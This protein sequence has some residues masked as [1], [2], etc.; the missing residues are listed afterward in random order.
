[1]QNLKDSKGSFGMTWE[2]DGTSPS[3]HPS[4]IEACGTPDASKS[5]NDAATEGPTSAFKQLALLDRFLAV[6]I[7]LAMAIGII[8]GNFVPNTSKALDKGKFVGVSVPIGMPLVSN[9][10]VDRM[11]AHTL[12][13][14]RPTSHDVPHSV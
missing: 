8:L 9:L 13:S 1:L 2:K 6:W 10:A 12:H 5:N 4:D 7:F 14:N 3:Q 11:M